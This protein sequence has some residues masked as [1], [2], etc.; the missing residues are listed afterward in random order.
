MED[1]RAVIHGVIGRRVVDGG[2]GSTGSTVH[3]ELQVE[4]RWVVIKLVLLLMEMIKWRRSGNVGVAW[5]WDW[6]VV[7]VIGNGF[8]LGQPQDGALHLGLDVVGFSGGCE[9]EGGGGGVSGSSSYKGVLSEFREG[10][11]H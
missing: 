9:V 5:A 8:L 4:I 7:L 3:G 2:A 11:G 1:G 10:K 6:E